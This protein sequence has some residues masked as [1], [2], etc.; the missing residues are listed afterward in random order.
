M[1]YPR[2]RAIVEGGSSYVHM[3]YSGPQVP[4]GLASTLIAAGEPAAKKKRMQRTHGGKAGDKVLAAPPP[5]PLPSSSL[6]T[7]LLTLLPTLRLALL[8]IRS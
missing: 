3:S 4:D 7:F 2:N 8:L 5:T 1:S 6:P